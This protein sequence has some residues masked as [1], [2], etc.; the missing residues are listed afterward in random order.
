[1]SEQS[2]H[3][4]DA[5]HP[6]PLNGASASENAETGTASHP[7]AAAINGGPLYRRNPDDPLMSE[8][9]ADLTA[10]IALLNERDFG[11]DDVEFHALGKADLLATQ[12]AQA[13]IKLSPNEIAEVYRGRPRTAASDLVVF[14]ALFLRHEVISRLFRAVEHHL[15]AI[16]APEAISGSELCDAEYPTGRGEIVNLLRSGG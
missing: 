1:M 5:N 12:R 13:L 11:F 8:G 16:V 14:R 3:P 6:S 9:E 2:P 15:H 10:A 7:N 4:L